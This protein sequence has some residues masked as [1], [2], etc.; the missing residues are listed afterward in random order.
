MNE[1]TIRGAGL[2][3]WAG[4]TEFQLSLRQA[5]RSPGICFSYPSPKPRAP[6]AVS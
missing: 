3:A 4:K 6:D 1:S 5:D 2:G